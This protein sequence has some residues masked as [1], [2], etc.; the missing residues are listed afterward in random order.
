MS[1]LSFALDLDNQLS[2]FGIIE[3]SLGASRTPDLHG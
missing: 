1:L 3:S 2:V